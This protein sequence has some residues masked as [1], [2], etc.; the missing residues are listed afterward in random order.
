VGHAAETTRRKD[1]KKIDDNLETRKDRFE[2]GGEE[3]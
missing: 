3:K 2:E 1:R